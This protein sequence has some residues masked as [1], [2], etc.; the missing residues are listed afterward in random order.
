MGLSPMLKDISKIDMHKNQERLTLS[1]EFTNEMRFTHLNVTMRGL[2]EMFRL[3]SSQPMNN[4][5]FVKYLHRRTPVSW[6]RGPSSAAVVASGP[7]PWPTGSWRLT[8][9]L[10]NLFTIELKSPLSTLNNEWPGNRVRRK[11]K[12]P[13]NLSRLRR[14][15]KQKGPM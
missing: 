1:L 5:G 7:I 11:S 6:V 12:T 9:E 13:E 14:M 4:D 2:A 15:S 8:L 3:V 10:G